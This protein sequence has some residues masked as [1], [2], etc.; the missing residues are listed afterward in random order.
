MELLKKDWTL[1]TLNSP[2]QN[3]G[4]WLCIILP[5]E[6]QC[7]ISSQ[8]TPVPEPGRMVWNEFPVLLWI[9]FGGLNPEMG[10]GSA[11]PGLALGC[12]PAPGTN[13]AFQGTE[14]ITG[15]SQKQLR[16]FADLLPFTWS[17]VSLKKV[18]FFSLFFSFFSCYPHEAFF[19]LSH[20]HHKEISV[21]LAALLP[22]LEST[23][24][25]WEIGNELNLWV[26]HY[27]L[28]WPEMCFY[29]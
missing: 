2:P 17:P 8:N 1:K 15:A 24:F 14:R 19:P 26:I 20:P 5:A 28:F 25:Q 18:Y 27:L 3:R 6:I 4:G 9:G 16:A 7:R 23:F 13:L 10:L 22:C 21:W 29:H 11:W 12:P